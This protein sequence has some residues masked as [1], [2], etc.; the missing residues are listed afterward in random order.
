[1]S[2]A[3]EYYAHWGA[4][5]HRTMKI[6]SLETLHADAGWRVFS[7]LKI[8]TDEGIVGY[9]EYNESYGSRGTTGVIEKLAPFIEGADPMAHD[10]I[11]S[12]LYAMTRQ[13]P[14]GRKRSPPAR[15]G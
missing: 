1:M 9:S 4:V 12:R 11:F 5:C 13:A 6:T 10:A 14:G 7:Y 3:V 15:N 8:A 2:V